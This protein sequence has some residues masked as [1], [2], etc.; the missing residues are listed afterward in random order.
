MD[1]QGYQRNEYTLQDLILRCMLAHHGELEEEILNFFFDHSISL[2]PRGHS[3]RDSE[4]F[5]ALPGFI[6]MIHMI[7]NVS[8]RMEMRPEVH[9]WIY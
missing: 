8:C 2:Q 6:P 1:G 3:Y 9:S 5:V 4:G 7:C